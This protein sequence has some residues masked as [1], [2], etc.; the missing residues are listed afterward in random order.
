LK[1]ASCFLAA[2]IALA[3][4]RAQEDASPALERFAGALSALR[5]GDASAASVLRE[6]A[7]QLCRAHGRCD[8]RAVA[9]YYLGLSAEARTQGRIDESAYAA[10]RERVRAAASAGLD[11]EA[12]AAER[13]Q[14]LAALVGLAEESER[15]PDFVPAAQALALAARIEAE[16]AE[17]DRALEASARALVARRA[18]QHARAA[19]GLFARAGQSTPRL[20]TEW[21][22]AK[23]ALQRGDIELARAG[24]E[25]LR[26]RALATRRDEYREHAVQGHLTLVR[27]AG[28]VRAEEHWLTELASFRAPQESWAL[29]RDWAVRLLAEDLA[30]AAAEFLERCEPSELAP[31]ADRAEWELL[32][33]SVALRRGDL[34]A[35]RAHFERIADD[36]SELAR[37]AR[38]ALALREGRA[39]D[40]LTELRDADIEE[41]SP[42]GRARASALVGEAALSIGDLA[43]A[44]RELE[45][46]F[47]AA[48][49]SEATLRA[50]SGAALSGSVIGEQLGLQTVVLLARALAESGEPL[51]AVARIESAHSR[52]LRDGAEGALDERALRAWASSFE[53]GLLTWIVGADGG[54]AAHVAPD[55]SAAVAPVPLGRAQ[56]LAAVRRLREAALDPRSDL[57]RID[58]LGRE[59]SAA[60]VPAPIAARLAALRASHQSEPRVLLLA[61]G[62][63]EA[64]P[65]EVL[66]IAALGADPA[67]SVL[68]GLPGSEPGTRATTQ[69]FAQWSICGDPLDS[70]GASLLRGAREELLALSN[71]AS[72]SVLALGP[73]FTR[74]R[75]ADLCRS[76]RP[77][78]IA[79]HLDATCGGLGAFGAAALRTSE[80]LALCSDE[81]AALRPALPLVVLST[82]WSSGGARVDA[83]GQLGISR[84]FLAGGTR[85]VIVTQWP[86]E[87]RAAA[88]AAAE[89]HRALRDGV[90]P[91]RA[92]AR[93]RA[94]LRERGT[95]PAEWASLRAIG[96]D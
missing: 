4:A 40:V 61:H 10:L 42:S 14:V 35:A 39:N 63:L 84:A 77:L 95:A 90:G 41:F 83:E 8:A 16:Q 68:P 78:H 38:G 1:L 6:A 92:T 55:G 88:R 17:S 64:L 82:C 60:L 72:G 53:L 86:V 47:D 22:L 19:Q 46:A 94:A 50:A 31:R 93:A 57:A 2:L 85:N 30:E 96:R 3:P 67:L 37:L 12:W 87:D 44:R 65:F 9:E 24:F 28:D 56:W 34:A 33:G 25:A 62:P 48:A 26:L 15:R 71:A 69:R 36:D 27:L 59:I 20:E 5:D 7:E 70:S 75:L 21:V 79:T 11:G 76:E 13:E 89:L 32:C 18:E 66:S 58:A 29:A 73:D 54:L 23:L 45:R 74:A 81:L 91:A 51:E 80:P 52:G 49:S 43:H